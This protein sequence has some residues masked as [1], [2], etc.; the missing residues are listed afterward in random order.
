MY[1]LRGIVAHDGS[2][3]GGHYWCYMKQGDLWWKF[4]DQLVTIVQQTEVD[5]CN[6]YML[7]YVIE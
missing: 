4:N 2:L 5:A 6:A 7:F 1:R 3:N